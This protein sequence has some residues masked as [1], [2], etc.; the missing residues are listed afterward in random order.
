MVRPSAMELIE[1]VLFKV[2]INFRSDDIAKHRLELLT[3]DV[4]RL[5]RPVIAVF[6]AV[7]E[8]VYLDALRTPGT[9]L[10]SRR[11]LSLIVCI[12]HS[13]GIRF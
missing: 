6:D 3:A 1:T 9:Q 2:S 7:T 5:I 10:L 13:H 8:V 11:T 12:I 4:F